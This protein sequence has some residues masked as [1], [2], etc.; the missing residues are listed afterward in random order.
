[1]VIWEVLIL[2]IKFIVYLGLLVFLGGFFIFFLVLFSL[3]K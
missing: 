3:E 1:M 2:F